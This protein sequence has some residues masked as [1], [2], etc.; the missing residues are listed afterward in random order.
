[1]SFRIHINGFLVECETAQEVLALTG[2]P[3][4][5]PIARGA[6]DG[7]QAKVAHGNRTRERR[8]RATE[9]T[10]RF[11]D[12]LAEAGPAGVNNSELVKH[13]QL[14]S[15]AAI[16]GLITPVNRILAKCGLE[17][18]AVYKRTVD[19]NRERRWT[20]GKLLEEGRAAIKKLKGIS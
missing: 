18:E 15:E 3:R 13:M 20:P 14:G 4:P 6:T 11:L 19:R 10:L 9:A 8:D 16:G 5:V 7:Q 2:A 17:Q 1:M 12:L